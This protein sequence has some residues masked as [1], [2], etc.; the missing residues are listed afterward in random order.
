M[1]RI[2]IVGVCKSLDDM[3]AASTSIDGAWIQECDP[4][5]DLLRLTKNESEAGMFADV[6]AML[7]SW[8][9]DYIK[10]WVIEVSPCRKQ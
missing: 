3:G 5:N 2:R 8:P 1:H 4:A 9:D 10:D 7:E 6:G